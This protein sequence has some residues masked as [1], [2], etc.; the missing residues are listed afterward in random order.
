MFSSGLE[1]ADDD[2]IIIFTHDKYMVYKKSH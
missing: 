1:R 2:V